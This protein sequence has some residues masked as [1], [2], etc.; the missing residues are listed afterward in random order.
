MTSQA[1]VASGV[2]VSHRPLYMRCQVWRPRSH[3]QG[4]LRV[5]IRSSVKRKQLDSAAVVGCELKNS[6]SIRKSRSREVLLNFHLLETLV[7]NTAAARRGR[8]LK[9][10]RTSELAKVVVGI[11]PHGE[12]YGQSS[13]LDI[14][15]CERSRS[16]TVKRKAHPCML[17]L[18]NKALR[19]STNFSRWMRG[20]EVRD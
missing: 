5:S 4:L 10:L 7:H 16:V 6:L 11:A 9:P 1:S 3:C 14:K 13:P 19:G 8:S 12:R 18:A 17:S 20:R 15:S 2:L